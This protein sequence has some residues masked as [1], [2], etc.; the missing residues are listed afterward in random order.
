MKS[1]RTASVVLL[2]F[3]SGMPLGLVWIAIPDWLRSAGVD[4]RVVGMFT[5]AQIPWSFNVLWA[6]FM[7]RYHLP[8]FGRRRGWAGLAQVLLLLCT[9]VLG[10]VGNDP[11]TPWVIFA[12]ALAIGVAAATQDVAI[13]AY[14]VDVLR[15]EEQGVA[16][17][18]RIGLYRLAM[19]V[20]GALAI[21]LSGRFSWFHVCLFL[22]LLYVPMLLVTAFAPEPEI[23]YPEPRTLKEAIWKPFLGFLSRDRALEI[24]AFVLLF[25][26]ADNFAQSL[27]RPFLVD[28]GYTEVERGVA[29]G[30]VGLWTQIGGALLGGIFTNLLGLGRAL[31][32]FGLLQVF[33]NVGYLYLAN[34]EHN[35]LAM[36]VAMGIETLCQG[37]GTG[38][39]SVLLLRM[40]QKR[41]SATQYALFST[42]FGMGRIFSGPVAGFTVDSVGWSWFFVSSMVLGIPGLVMLYRFVPFH[43]REPEFEVREVEPLPALSTGQLAG[44]GVLAGVASTLL[45]ALTMALLTAL[46]SLRTEP[47]RGFDLVYSLAH[48]LHPEDIVGWIQI[49]S[50]LAVGGCLGLLTAATMAARRGTGL[51]LAREAM[52]EQDD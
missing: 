21:T 24:L 9:I 40:T 52:L 36:I 16:V 44:R 22:G 25:K 31:W 51:D 42:L 4:I 12:F 3:S 50:L 10:G 11:E 33:S 23:R 27:L 28:M 41:F 34:T 19:F 18:A 26:F 29:L 45:A 20:S 38:A 5:L 35:G 14:A 1:W 37:L 13:D 46:K 43:V 7:D 48:M 17:G 32:V 6:P 49:V 2:S 39:F 30:V 47:E 8:F 15:R